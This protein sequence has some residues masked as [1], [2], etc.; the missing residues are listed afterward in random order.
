[1]VS[2]RS[3]FEKW[4]YGSKCYDWVGYDPRSSVVVF[5]MVWTLDARWS[6]AECSG[7][8]YKGLK[9]LKCEQSQVP[10]TYLAQTS[11]SQ[12]AKSK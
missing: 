2:D 1:M 4:D 10:R 7:L 8:V 11:N 5:C 12:P 3:H 6:M 9:N